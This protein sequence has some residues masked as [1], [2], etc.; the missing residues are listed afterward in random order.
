MTKRALIT[1]ITGQDGAYM[2]A[3]LVE[4]GYVVFGGYRRS[5]TPNFWRLRALGVFDQ[6]ALVGLDLGDQSSLSDVI[7]FSEPDEI[8]NFAAQSSVPVSFDQPDY[9]NDVNSGGVF[10][11]LQAIRRLRP[12]CRLYQASSSEMFGDAPTPQ[13]IGSP[14]RPRSPYACAKVAAHLACKNYREAYNLHVNCGIAFNHESPLRGVEFVTKKITQSLA[15]MKVSDEGTLCLGNIFSRRDW[16][17]AGDYVQAMW[18]MLQADEPGDY[19]I[20]TGKSRSIQDFVEAACETIGFEIEWAGA[21][22]DTVGI[23]METARELVKIDPSLYRP[24]DVVDL[25][26]DPT[27]TAKTLGWKAETSLKELAELM[28]SYDLADAK[29]ARQS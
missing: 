8:Y 7:A 25:C 21:G 12:E 20:C 18:Q 28:A 15:H 14:F 3:L 24:T 10:R 11:I 23:C 9:T 4:K 6:I 5:S 13:S 22:E 1:G 19:V 26:G 17:F 16:G 27:L 29:A 2:A